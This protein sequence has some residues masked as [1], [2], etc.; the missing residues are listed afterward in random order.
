[1]S[2]FEIEDYTRLVHALGV[3]WDVGI[4]V[5]LASRWRAEAEG[6]ERHLS[7]KTRYVKGIAIVHA[8]HALPLYVT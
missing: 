1:V 5:V 8:L 3:S 7:H 6:Q 4:D 2:C